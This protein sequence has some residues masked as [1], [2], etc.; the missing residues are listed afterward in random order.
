MVAPGS[1]S[2]LTEHSLQFI[3]TAPWSSS[4]AERAD[5]RPISSG[6]SLFPFLTARASATT[7]HKASLGT[8]WSLKL[9]ANLGQQGPSRLRNSYAG[10]DK[11]AICERLVPALAANNIGLF[12][13]RFTARLNEARLAAN[14]ERHIRRAGLLILYATKSWQSSRYTLLERDLACKL[15]RPI[16][17]VLPSFRVPQLSFLVTRC[18]FRNDASGDAAALRKAIEEALGKELPE[19]AIE[20]RGGGH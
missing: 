6:L 19:P 9:S 15:K 3:R 17:A 1:K 12:D 5:L 18:R 20:L 11:E 8:S 14:I 4:G 10:V 13:Y 7:S 2:P 16:V